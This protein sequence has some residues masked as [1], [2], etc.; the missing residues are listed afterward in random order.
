MP[1]N[2]ISVSAITDYQSVY[3]ALPIIFEILNAKRAEVTIQL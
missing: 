2:C 1:G 3:L